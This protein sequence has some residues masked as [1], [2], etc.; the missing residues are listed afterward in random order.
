MKK[1]ERDARRADAITRLR[2]A[3]PAGSTVYTVLLNASRSGMSRTI[4]CL[5]VINEYDSRMDY[6]ESGMTSFSKEITGS[7]IRDISM[8]VA[9]ALEIR[10]S[11]DQE[12]VII[13]GCGMDMGFH[14]VSSL[15][16]VLF[17][18]S[19]DP[20]PDYVIKHRWV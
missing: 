1:S 7:H 2:E 13:G 10:L 4:K 15:S 14:I 5:A 19:V 20:A 16:R 6:D 8:D 9:K 12:G 3:I 17:P 18:D 11:K